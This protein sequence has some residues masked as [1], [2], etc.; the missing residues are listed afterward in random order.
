V[1]ESIDRPDTLQVNGW[2]F[3]QPNADQ[4]PGRTPWAQ[5]LQGQRPS[6]FLAPAAAADPRDWQHPDIGWGLV[7]PEPDG[8]VA[9][10]ARATAED[11]LKPIRDLL[12]SRPGSPV[13]RWAPTM[14]QNYLRRY[15]ADG[16]VQDL[17]VEAPAPGTQFGRIP[18]YLLICASPQQIPWSVQYALNMSTFV[19]RLDLEEPQLATYI[20]ALIH[21]WAGQSCRPGAPVVWSADHGQGDITW[22]M[23]QAVAGKLWTKFESDTDLIGRL[24]LKDSDATA[25]NLATAL[26]E[27]SP[28]LIVTTSHGVTGPASDVAAL[29]A[30]L[31]MPIDVNRIPL[32]LDDL[33][34]WKPFGAI[35]YAHA[36]CS[37]GSDK[38]SRY[39]G[40]LPSDNTI[41][42]MLTGVAG[43]AG[44]TVA[45]LPRALLSRDRPLRAFVGHVEP[46][47]DW[48]LR[49][50][51][52]KQPLTHVLTAAL[53]DKLYQQD[54]RTPIGFALRSVFEEAGAF[55]ATWAQAIAG[56]N[57]NVPNMRDWALYRQ[58]VAMDRQTTVIIGDPTV[59]LPRLN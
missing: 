20:D 39:D 27:R 38:P 33:A 31:G 19:G 6:P 21:D 49:D 10:A 36:C 4:L 52:T 50:P 35:W 28:G 2:A 24:R 26:T 48:T 55:Y 46:T 5:R 42:R 22:L 9:P 25:A 1:S 14:Q 32:R 57:A 16:R 18:R 23:A 53:Y 54:R 34:S 56:I 8:A 41:S 59:S 45:P 3:D 13:L 43:A 40:L 29:T 37:G 51:R 44:Q 11:A 47:F 7:L 15:Y 12:A 58:L 17:S 30:R